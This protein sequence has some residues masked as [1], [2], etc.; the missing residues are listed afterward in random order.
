MHSVL[1][2]SFEVRIRHLNGLL[3]LVDKFK[4]ET[5]GLNLTELHTQIKDYVASSYNQ[6]AWYDTLSLAQ[7]NEV[8]STLA[9][10]LDLFLFRLLLHFKLILILKYNF[11]LLLLPLN[12]HVLL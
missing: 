7:K 1:K 6:K 5:N 3:E 4:K 10:L 9:K 11:E 8:E 2:K 12:A